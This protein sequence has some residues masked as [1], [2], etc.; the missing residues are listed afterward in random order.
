LSSLVRVSSENSTFPL[1]DMFKN[2]RRGAVDTQDIT[3]D[4]VTVVGTE[5]AVVA[6]SS[7]DAYLALGLDDL[8]QA[9][10]KDIDSVRLSDV[11]D[12]TAL[13]AV[14][15]KQIHASNDLIGTKED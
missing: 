3:T 6:A 10:H 2:R 13:F 14:L 8:L 1:K 9:Q 12:F 4:S 15:G 11:K 7:F 5:D